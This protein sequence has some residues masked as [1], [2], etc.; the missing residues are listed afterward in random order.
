MRAQ[1]DL[2]RRP[3]PSG[4]RALRRSLIGTTSIILSILAAGSPAHAQSARAETLFDDGDRLMAEGKLAEACDAFEASNRIEPRAGTL[5][6]LGECR[7]QNQQ[8]AS[9]WSAYKRALD[10]VRDPKKREFAAAR[11][12]ALEPQ[13]SYLT[14]SVS[15][16]SQI[17]GLTLARN[18]TSL[19]P[20]LWNQPQP[21]DGGDYLITVRAP[22]HAEW[23]TTVNVAA[24]G[25]RGSVEVP[26]LEKLSKA[27]SPM[28]STPVSATKTSTSPPARPWGMLTTKRKIAIGVAGTSVVSLVTGVVLGTSANHKQ[29]DAFRL[30]P[31]PATPC[32]Q[33][34]RANSLI[35]SSHSRALGANVAF[36]LATGA[37]ITAGVLWFIGAPNAAAEDTKR[38][39]VAP[40]MGPGGPSVI[41]VG[42]F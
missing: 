21:I 15:E 10:R 41:V 16:A 8:L 14:V 9:A 42:R 27:A 17:E 6:R 4:E 29:D 36:T 24:I 18:G 30:C 38:V 11:V 33:G 28:P 23:Q 35:Q 19:E 32:M 39:S 2:Q 22:D 1:R 34:D 7:E 26:R 40:S 31:D 13:L 3:R 25:A 37:A 12:A 5:I 20:T